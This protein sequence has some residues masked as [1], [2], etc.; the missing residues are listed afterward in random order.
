MVDAIQ[1]G[2]IHIELGD[3]AMARV[4]SPCLCWNK[5]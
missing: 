1:H 4:N 3:E 2:V 5:W